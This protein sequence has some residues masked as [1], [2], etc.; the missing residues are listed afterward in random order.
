MLNFKLCYENIREK[1]I[2]T[3]DGGDG[4][5]GG[6]DHYKSAYIMQTLSK[7]NIFKKYI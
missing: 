1:V 4:N 6:Y 7:I 5:F 3:G 2:M